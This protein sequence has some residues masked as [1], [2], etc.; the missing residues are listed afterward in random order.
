MEVRELVKE[1]LL[2]HTVIDHLP[3]L[4]HAVCTIQYVEKKE[5]GKSRNT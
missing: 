5:K 2:L 3:L 4:A 1:L